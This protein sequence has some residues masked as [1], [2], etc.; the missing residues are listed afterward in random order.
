[1]LSAGAIKFREIVASDPNSSGWKLPQEESGHLWETERLYTVAGEKK[2]A[3]STT[4]RKLVPYSG[5]RLR[6]PKEREALPGQAYLARFLTVLKHIN[7]SCPWC[8]SR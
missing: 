7:E 8:S 5:F 1:M 4:R 2:L 6:P 3:V